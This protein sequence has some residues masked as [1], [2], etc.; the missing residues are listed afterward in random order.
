MSDNAA[1]E[2]SARQM[3]RNLRIGWP[4]RDTVVAPLDTQARQETKERQPDTVNLMAECVQAGVEW[5]HRRLCEQATDAQTPHVWPLF[6]GPATAAPRAWS[7]TPS[8]GRRENHQSGSSSH[9]VRRGYSAH[10][11]FVSL[12][13]LRKG[14]AGPRGHRCLV[15]SQPVGAL[16]GFGCTDQRPV[17]PKE[18]KSLSSGATPNQPVHPH[19]RRD[20]EQAP[21]AGA[22]TKTSGSG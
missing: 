4:L 1:N 3:H 9:L 2:G 5:T 18:R 15:P 16:Q 22:T 12:D 20:D 10:R 7:L 21:I 19:A 6:T 8:S 13:P 17:A 11:T 14:H